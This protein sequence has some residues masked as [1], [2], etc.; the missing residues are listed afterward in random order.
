MAISMGAF[1]MNHVESVFPDSHEF[2][3]E[4]WLDAQGQRRKDLDRYLMS[5]SKG[6]RQC[7]GIKWVYPVLKLRWFGALPA[8][9]P[10]PGVLRDVPGPRGSHPA[11]LS[12]HEAV[13]DDH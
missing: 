13:P 12:A 4:R 10:K 6:S 1:V 3:P 11:R 8:D 2:V 9:N 5:F 7:L